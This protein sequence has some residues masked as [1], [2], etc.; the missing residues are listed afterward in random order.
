MAP[1]RGGAVLDADRGFMKVALALAKRH[2]PWDVT[3]LAC[4]NNYAVL[5]VSVL[6]LR[7]EGS[8]L[9]R[10]ALEQLGKMHGVGRAGDQTGL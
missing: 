10:D 5:L 2:L 9:V 6:G 7:E 4:V 8:Q 3:R 1:E